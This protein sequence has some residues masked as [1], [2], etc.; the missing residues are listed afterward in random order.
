MRRP[1]RVRRIA[2][3]MACLAFVL[4]LCASCG[5]ADTNSDIR[6][7]YSGTYTDKQG[8]DEIYSSL[9]LQPKGDGTYTVALSLYRITEMTGTAEEVD[10]GRLRFDC[11]V[12]DFGIS[13]DI[14]IEDSAAQ[15]SVTESNFEYVPVGT[16]YFFPDGE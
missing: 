12:P 4:I 5:K 2:R 14:L 16:E 11:G 9:A 3:R 1:R 10:A 13:G 8:T 15:V 7:D 6:E